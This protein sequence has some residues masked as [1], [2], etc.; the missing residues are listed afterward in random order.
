MREDIDWSYLI[1]AAHGHRVM[2]FLNLC[3]NAV[4]PT[5][6]PKATMQHLQVYFHVNALHN[7]RQSEELVTVLA[8]FEQHGIPAIPFKGPVLAASL[9]CNLALR[10]FEDLDIL[11]PKRYIGQAKDLLVTRGY[12]VRVGTGY[13]REYHFSSR[14]KRFEI[15]LHWGLTGWPFPFPVNLKSWWERLEPVTLF[16]TTVVRSF[17]P[18]DLLL[19]LCCH[20]ANR[21]AWICD[22]SE[23][24]RIHQEMDLEKIIDQAGKLRI[25]RL[26]FLGLHLARN[27]IG[28]DIPPRVLRLIQGDSV[29]L[30]LAKQFQ[31]RLFDPVDG[32]FMGLAGTGWGFR[33]R[34]CLQDRVC[35]LLYRV[36]SALFGFSDDRVGQMRKSNVTGNMRRP[37]RLFRRN[38]MRTF[39]HLFWGR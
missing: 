33:Q 23:L 18:P 4:D 5:V 25:Q 36:H 8:L 24:L 26:L 30:S 11:V 13:A 7:R 38:G 1:R 27:L 32:A 16:G 10:M 29:S 6:V 14:G 15:D 34:E 31:Q 17:S 19:Y 9:Y 12:Q 35:Y 21:L 3:L 20:G 39:R 37:F 2:P 28:V 22:V